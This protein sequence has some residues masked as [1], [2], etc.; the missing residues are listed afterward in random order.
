MSWLGA[1]ESVGRA[2][3]E[4]SSE[5]QGRGVP[6]GAQQAPSGWSAIRSVAAVAGPLLSAVAHAAE[7]K[8]RQTLMPRASTDMLVLALLAARLSEAAYAH[9][10]LALGAMLADVPGA[11]AA[12]FTVLRFS[13]QERLAAPP[14]APY[15]SP[16]R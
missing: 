6:S 13:P 16:D 5:G 4:A 9:D 11:Q 7:R 10:T 8:M 12:D 1:L 15:R 3:A 2:F 14:R